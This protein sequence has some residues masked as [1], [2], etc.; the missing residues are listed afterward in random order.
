MMFSQLD[1]PA[2]TGPFDLRL[3]VDGNG[4]N[5]GPIFDVWQAGHNVVAIL[6][7][8]I[9]PRDGRWHMMTGTYNNGLQQLF[10]DGALMKCT[11]SCT[12]GGPLPTNS[13]GAVIGGQEFGPYNHPWIGRLDE[14][15]IY[16]RVLSN[17]EVL[18]L[19]QATN[20]PP[21]AT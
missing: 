20:P 13:V 6:V 2:G 12:F 3:S 21:K 8:Q 5:Q 9:N 19:Y 1:D 18:K 10:V 14:A 11:L 4:R 17:V 7:P 15:A 16:N